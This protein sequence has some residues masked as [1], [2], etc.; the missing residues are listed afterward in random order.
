MRD[1]SLGS[2]VVVSDDSCV[3]L[4]LTSGIV[5]VVSVECFVDSFSTLGDS[6]EIE[7]DLGIIVVDVG[8][9]EVNCGIIEV[10]SLT[11][12]VD[13]V[14]IEVDSVT[15]VADSVTI[16]VNSGRTDVDSV[17]VKV[18]SVTIPEPSILSSDSLSTRGV[19]VVTTTAGVPVLLL[20]L[21]ELKKDGLCLFLSKIF[22]PGFLLGF[23]FGR[24]IPETGRGAKLDFLLAMFG[25]LAGDD[26]ETLEVRE[27]I[28]LLGKAI[29]EPEAKLGLL[30]D[31]I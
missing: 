1:D 21:L 5:C 9:R 18:E 10:D 29:L 16:E 31:V 28:G 3:A 6:E 15:I 27:V 14:T 8:L 7:V 24:T 26:G 17:S 23:E 30:G 4:V 13:S 19:C 25:L 20:D 12:E 11:I 2:V 22:C